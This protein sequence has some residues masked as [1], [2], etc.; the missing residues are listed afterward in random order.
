MIAPTAALQRL[1]HVLAEGEVEAEVML[2][3]GAV[4]SLVFDARPQTRR[5]S[6]LLGDRARFDEAVDAVAREYGLPP[7]WLS[8]ATRN[9]V[10]VEG[11]LGGGF[12]GKSL[13]VFSPVP[14]Y[15]L[16]MKCAELAGAAGD[17]RKLVEAD[18]RYLLR[19]TGVRTVHDALER[20]YT[21]FNARQL[22]DDLAG[23]LRD[24]L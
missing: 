6:A 24:L 17:D 5:A 19:L 7:D 18:L 15:V 12:D 4:M 13:R 1:E 8:T 10:A 21:Y 14:D 9:L 16:A 22:P 2:T 3:G 20:V 23:T 11:T